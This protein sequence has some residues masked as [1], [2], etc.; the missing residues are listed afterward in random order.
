MSP[1]GNEIECVID[2]AAVVVVR[3]SGTCGAP[4]RMTEL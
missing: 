1:E 2:K 3:G 4:L